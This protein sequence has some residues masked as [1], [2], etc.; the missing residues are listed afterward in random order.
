MHLIINKLYTR[1][2]NSMLGNDMRACGMS[3]VIE[4]GAR[5]EGEK[6]RDTSNSRT[7]TRIEPL[8]LSS[9][10]IVFG[11]RSRKHESGVCGGLEHASEL[12]TFDKYCLQFGWIGRC[13]YGQH[14]LALLYWR[15]LLRP[16]KQCIHCAAHQVLLKL[17]LRSIDCMNCWYCRFIE[18]AYS[19]SICLSLH[20]SL[21]RTRNGSYCCWCNNVGHS[22]HRL[23]EIDRSRFHLNRSWRASSPFSRT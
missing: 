16:Y 14:S 9:D 10:M 20:F 8:H 7:D 17:N 13:L 23:I 21:R 4:Q 3:I 2:N 22:L 19:I 6:P 11:N 12:F 5:R 15:L 18:N 1:S